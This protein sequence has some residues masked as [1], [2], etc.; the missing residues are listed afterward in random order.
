MKWTVEWLERYTV[1]RF[2]GELMVGAAQFFEAG[3][4][5]WL[6][7][8][9]AP[10]I[11]DLSSVT[12]IAS[13]GLGSLLRIQNAASEASVHLV[14]VKPTQEAWQALAM[15]RLDTLLPCADTV[16]AAVALVTNRSS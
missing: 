12:I 7:M 2:E 8:P 3:V 9:F 1:L 4:L 15:T 10:I 16:E 14:L 13:A 6:K 11:L 5:P